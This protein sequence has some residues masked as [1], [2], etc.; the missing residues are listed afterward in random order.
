MEFA[1]T[2]CKKIGTQEAYVE[3]GQTDINAVYFYRATKPSREEE[4]LHF[5]YDF[6]SD[7]S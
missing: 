4:V 6:K 7:Q 5:S 2:Y 1:N 3:A